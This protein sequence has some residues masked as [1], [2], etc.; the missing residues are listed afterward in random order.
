MKEGLLDG[1]IAYRHNE[2]A[3]H[4]ET[5]VLVHG[6]TG[7]SSVWV[8]FE[9]KFT[10]TYNILSFD[11]RGHGLSFKPRHYRDYALAK[12]AYD[13]NEL[14]EYLDIKSFHLINHSFGTMVG[15]Q[16]LHMYEHKVSTVVFLSPNYGIHQSLRAHIAQP[17]FMFMV[18]ITT[19][20]PFRAKPRGRVDYANFTKTGDF[21]IRRSILDLRNTTLRVYF[22]CL[23]HAYR[24]NRNVW[25]SKVVKPTL[26]IHGIHDKIIS[27]KN[28]VRMAKAMSH[29]KL[30][31]L[32][33]SDHVMVIND[34]AETEH[35]L[36][37]F[38][39]DSRTT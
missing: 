18:R 28:A 19:L 29:A 39:A 7:S 12:F 25:W 23:E 2:F 10:H 30:V 16:Y 3:P 11:L 32:E 35:I 13:L 14:V 6:L 17:F 4:R 22:Y 5:L 24:F 20:F 31:L 38:L 27:Y 8:P 21:N 33:E 37:G 9:R 36:E 26:I 34:I 15:L 1:R